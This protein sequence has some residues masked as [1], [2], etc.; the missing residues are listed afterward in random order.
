MI[1]TGSEPVIP[2][3]PGLVES[4]YWTNR[5]VTALHELPA[6]AVIVGG[7]PVGI[8]LAQFL[9]RFECAVTVVQGAERLADREDQRV[10]ELLVQALRSGRDR[11]SHQ[12]A[13]DAGLDR[14]R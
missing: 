12:R 6:S 13:R 3:V 7:G 2:P 8:E 5:E 1:S 14:R 9:R 11:R 10:S 4:G